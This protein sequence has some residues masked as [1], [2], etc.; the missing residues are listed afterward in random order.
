[1][2]IDAWIERLYAEQGIVSNLGEE[3]ADILMSWTESQL[4]AAETDA[5][6]QHLLDSA[7]LLARYVVAG[8]SFEQ[9]LAAFKANAFAQALD[10]AAPSIGRDPTVSTVYP[11]ES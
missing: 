3:R 6:A 10:S 2:D 9:L 7:R 5:E 4:A 1:M 8:G 11:P